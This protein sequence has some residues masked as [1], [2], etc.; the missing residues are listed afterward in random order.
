MRHIV[1]P[2][3]GFSSTA[4]RIAEGDYNVSIPVTTKDEIGVLSDAFN[5][6]ARGIKD[7]SEALAQSRER[8]KNA[9][10]I[11]HIGNWDWDMVNNELL[12]SDEI[13][14][15]FGIA[16]T[17]FGATY[18]AFLGAVH[19]EDRELVKS[20]VNEALSLGCNYSIDHR[21]V[22]PS[23]EVRI[24]HEQAEIIR[25]AFGTP[26]MMSGTVQDITE[27]K[28]AENEVRKLNAEL[29]DKVKERTAELEAAIKGLESFSYSVAHD[30]RTPLRSIDGFSQAF[31]EDYG[32]NIGPEGHDYLRRI[33]EGS[34]RMGHLIDDLLTLSYVTRLEMRREEVDLSHLADAVA[35]EQNKTVTGRDV[36]FIAAHGLKATGDPGLLRIVLD[37]LIGNS[38][39][40]TGK[41]AHAR[42]G[43]YSAGKE[44]ART[45][46]CVRDNGVGFDMK[47]YSKLF[48]PFQRLHSTVDFRGTGIGLATVER[49]ICR[50]GGRV[51]AEAEAGKG[52]AFYFTL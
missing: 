15:M 31:I 35:D 16:Q 30:L 29:E 26:V 48:V 1:K 13:Y 21:I 34:Q 20:A 46:Y 6:M 51:W 49:I 52:A 32:E 24:V 7:R 5:S 45:I 41:Q 42:I 40:F 23:G 8:L 44:G 47:Y 11:A 33:R 3:K 12:W 25:D 18:E 39:K 22:L 28:T 19:P 43:F 14:R 38:F 2:L 10:R 37:N 17:E 36:E 50:H 4:I 27:R 9:Q